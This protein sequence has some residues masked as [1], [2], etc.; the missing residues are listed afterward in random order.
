MTVAA[1]VIASFL[2]ARSDRPRWI[3]VSPE[4]RPQSIADGYRV[5]KAVHGAIEATGNRRVGYKVAAIAVPGQRSFG[6]DE[7]L[8][9][10]IFADNQAQS[11]QAALSV[12]L[13][14]PSLECEI[15]FCLRSGIDGADPS[16]TRQGVAKAI[17]ACHI[18]CEIV[19]NRYG[20][21]L[22]IGVPSL[23]ADDFFHASFVLG[24]PNPNWQDLDLTKLNAA[25]EIDGA[26]VKANSAN[27]LDALTSLHWLARKL[28]GAGLCLR[29]GDIVL[30]GSIVPPTRV[31][32]PIKSASLSI[33]GFSQ[34]TLAS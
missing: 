9:A 14:E 12:P 18:A 34:L 11:L 16:L 4:Y 3:P 15:A 10:G 8:Y 25:I 27:V 7:P 30:S 23:L 21:P 6:I 2:H 20:D 17:G 31:T 5:Q 28:S 26:V 19:D 13:L 29:A 33:A 1:D 32:L 24:I 22:A